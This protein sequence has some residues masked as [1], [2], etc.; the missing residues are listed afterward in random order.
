MS[1]ERNVISIRLRIDQQS[2][3][4][5]ADISR[6]SPRNRPNR[7][8]CLIYLGLYIA[9]KDIYADSNKASENCNEGNAIFVRIRL[10]PEHIELANVFAPTHP[11]KRSSV[12]LSLACRGLEVLA[13]G[14]GKDN[15][16][17]REDADVRNIPSDSN[18]MARGAAKSP[19]KP[20]RAKKKKSSTPSDFGFFVN[21]LGL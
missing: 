9:N 18:K 8:I 2:P 12:G 3:D 5:M 21:Q 15:P 13:A 16:Q 19:K 17:V 11:K 4:L 10:R 6:L 20:K 7:L 14:N 1:N